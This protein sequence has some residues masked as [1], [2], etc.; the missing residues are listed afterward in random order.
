MIDIPARS[1]SSAV[2]FAESMRAEME[3]LMSYGDLADL[4]FDNR[5]NNGGAWKKSDLKKKRDESKKAAKRI[6]E[7]E[8]LKVVAESIGLNPDSLRNRLKRYGWYEPKRFKSR[9]EVDKEAKRVNAL[10]MRKN[11]LK[12]ALEGSTITECQYH[13][14]KERLSLP[15]IAKRV[16]NR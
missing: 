7:G 1:A 11:S 4:G 8:S 14:A 13:R 12:A 16:N 15:K 5:K 6:Q 10:A 9:S 2:N 3:R